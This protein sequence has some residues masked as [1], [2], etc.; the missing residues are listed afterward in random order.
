MFEGTPFLVLDLGGGTFD[1][2]AYQTSL[3]GGELSVNVLAKD[4]KQNLGGSDWDDVLVRM[5]ETGAKTSVAQLSQEEK[6]EL[7]LEAERAA[8]P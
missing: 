5:W 2:T 7:K 6:A 8:A 3:G 4:G 1:V